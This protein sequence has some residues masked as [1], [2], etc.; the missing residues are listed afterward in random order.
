MR[1]GAGWWSLM[2]FGYIKPLL[3]C[4]YIAHEK[5]T[6]PQMGELPDNV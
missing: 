4:A 6:L 3:D 2:T 5:V 1:A